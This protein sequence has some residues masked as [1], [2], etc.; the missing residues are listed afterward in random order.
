MNSAINS[1]LRWSYFRC[2]LAIREKQLGLDH[3]QVAT[4]LN[5][6]AELLRAQGNYAEAES[7]YR[8]GMV[9]PK[10]FP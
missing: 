8:R 7:M 5:N 10:F 3:P 2:T 1:S 9:H 4:S 6:L